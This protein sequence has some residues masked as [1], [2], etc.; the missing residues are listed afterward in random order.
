VNPPG[1]G[2]SAF[3]QQLEVVIGGPDYES[4]QRWSESVM[5]SMEDNHDLLSVDTN[6]EETQPQ[7]NV[8]LNRERAADFGLSAQDVGQTLQAM[9]ATLQASTYVDRGREYDVLL[10]ANESEARVPDDVNPIYVRTDAGELVPL[11]S[12]VDLKTVGASPELRR[13]DRLPAIT[14]SANMAEGY[15]LGRA[16]DF[17]EQT[18][19]DTLPLEARLSY[20]G[21]AEE[22]TEASS[23]IFITFGLALLIV[24]LVLA[25]QFE[26]WIHPLIIMLT[27][28]LA[29]A[30]AI[31]ALRVSGNSL[32]IY[33]QIGMIML[34]G[35]MAKNGILIV[36]FANQLRDQGY[37]VA[38]A[39]Y[40]GAIIRFR[41]VLMTGVSTIFGAV[42]LV[43]A[44]GAG[45]ESRITIG[46]VILGG[47]LF[48]TVLTLF[49]I[50][51][52][53]AWLAPYAKS[54]DAVKHQLEQELPGAPRQTPTA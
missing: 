36:E 26:S 31:L 49:I 37:S 10:E 27:V 48:A 22:F 5:A 46:V 25:A 21:M 40:Q 47:L 6:Y 4:V 11:S 33:S 30:G 16:I 38:E 1:L 39:A 34:L 35:L 54:A 51:V 42:P 18:V 19:N 15:D 8:E 45:A 7:L 20:K 17:I 2:Q 28:P 9:F 13:V 12:V 32:N 24:F 53:Y 52:L 50:P 23:A 14:L 41:P 44:T 43:L 3:N 29:I